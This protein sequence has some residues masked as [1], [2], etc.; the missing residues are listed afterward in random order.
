MYLAFVHF[1][2][3]EGYIAKIERTKWANTHTHTHI[4][5]MHTRLLSQGVRNQTH[6]QMANY[7]IDWWRY[8]PRFSVLPLFVRAFVFICEYYTC[9]KQ[10]KLDSTSLPWIVYRT[11]HTKCLE[12]WRFLFSFSATYGC[13]FWQKYWSESIWNVLKIRLR[14]AVVTRTK[15]PHI[16]RVDNHTWREKTNEPQK[17]VCA[18]VWC[19][20]KTEGRERESD[21]NNGCGS[22]SSTSTNNIKKIANEIHLNAIS[23]V[24]TFK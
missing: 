5:K 8:S 13:S 17:C 7:Y 21:I 23:S 1:N 16:Y 22:S 10:W 9:T 20:Y 11:R 19:A 15:A 2:G 3:G 12:L 24:L 14:T 18:C 6:W 4:H